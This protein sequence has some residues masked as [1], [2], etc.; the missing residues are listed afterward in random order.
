M[1]YEVHVFI[2]IATALASLTAIDNLFHV[3]GPATEKEGGH[4]GNDDDN[5]VRDDEDDDRFIDRPPFRV[6]QSSQLNVNLK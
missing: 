3:V 6:P 2:D 5:S 4:T 1:M